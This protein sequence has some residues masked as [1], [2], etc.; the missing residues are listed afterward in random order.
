M[1]WPEIRERFPHKWLLIEVIK[2]HTDG[3]KRVFEDIA[4]LDTFDDSLAALHHFSNLH[5]ELPQRELF[6]LH[7][8]KEKLDITEY[9]WMGIRPRI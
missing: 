4:V 5:K 6:V 3:K 8:D 9:A 2:A 7:T 1:Q